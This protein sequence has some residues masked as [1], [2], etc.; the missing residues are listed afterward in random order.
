VEIT[1]GY[2][3]IELWLEG[4]ETRWITGVV[5]GC[6]CIGERAQ[7]YTCWKSDMEFLFLF[8]WDEEGQ[9]QLVI[10]CGEDCGDSC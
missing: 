10:A 8:W 2:T 1:R 4:E 7:N 5:A 9:I 3:L 6:Q